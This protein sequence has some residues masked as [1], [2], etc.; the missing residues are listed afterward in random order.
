MTCGHLPLRYPISFDQLVL[1]CMDK[2]SS[3]EEAEDLLQI[4]IA[5]DSVQRA[6]VLYR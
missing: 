2:I 4:M 6:H 3:E 1:I 5:V